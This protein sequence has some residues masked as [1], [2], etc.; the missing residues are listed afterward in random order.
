MA[1]QSQDGGIKQSVKKLHGSTMTGRGMFLTIISIAEQ[2]MVFFP[3]C[4]LASTMCG[5]P[6]PQRHRQ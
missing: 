1:M 3:D 5:L 6:A 4:I 2:A